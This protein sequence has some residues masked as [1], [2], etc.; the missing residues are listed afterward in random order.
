MRYL[1]LSTHYRRPID[2]TDEVIADAK[3]GCRIS[4]GSSSASIG[5]SGK[6]DDKPARHGA[7]LRRDAADR[8]R[9]VRRAVLELKMKFLEMMDDDFNTAGAIAVLQELAGEINS[10]IERSGW[11]RKKTP[12]AITAVAGRVADACANWAAARLVHST[13][14]PSRARRLPPAAWPTEKSLADQLMQLI[15]QLRA[16]ARRRK[17]FATADAIRDG[18]AKMKIT[19]EDRADGTRWRKE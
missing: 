8:R 11:K 12:G 7:H 4:S 3:K 6:P 10:Y 13:R 1:L 19:L 18:L 2:F 9:A 14:R 16:T 15:I 17:D 5:S